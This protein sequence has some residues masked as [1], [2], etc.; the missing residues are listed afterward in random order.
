MKNL[1]L[2]IQ[3]ITLSSIILYPMVSLS[4]AVLPAKNGIKYPTD[5]KDW[6]VL[7]SSYRTDNNT[8][9]IILGNATAVKVSRAGKIKSWPEGSILAKL[10][11]K[12]KEL[13]NWK[14]AIVPGEFVHA[15]IMVKNAK[16]YKKTGGW[17]Y[18]RWKGE[19]LVVHGKDASAAQ[20]CFACHTTVKTSDYV[21]TVPA[22]M[23]AY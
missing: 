2:T 12:N 5:L 11:W 16:L 21:F 8:Q 17:G 3:V 18:A 15:E 14:A 10:V 9:R 22:I 4:E 7:S 13:P 6:K 23:P 20:E 1:A 19:S